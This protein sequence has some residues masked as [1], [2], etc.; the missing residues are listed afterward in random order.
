MWST[1]K[2]AIIHFVFFFLHRFDFICEHNSLISFHFC[3]LFYVMEHKACHFLWCIFCL[4][5]M[6]KTSILF[7]ERDAKQNIHVYM[8]LHLSNQNKQFW[9]Y[10]FIE[11]LALVK[12]ISYYASQIIIE[13][14]LFRWRSYFLSDHL[15][16]MM[17]FPK[18]KIVDCI[19][20]N[21][22]IDSIF[23]YVPSAKVA[24]L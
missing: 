24:P 10:H 20:K 16:G 9:E 2:D 11:S 7:L 3:G 8:Q 1:L 13:L 23:H 12:Q 14:N 17:A 15:L 18:I 22:W 21:N 4:Q 6:Q 5:W 19:F